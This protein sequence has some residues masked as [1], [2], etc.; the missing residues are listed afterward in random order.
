[1]SI[2]LLRQVSP[3]R[4]A[5]MARQ[6]HLDRALATQ[7]PTVFRQ[8]DHMM[9]PF[10]S[11]FNHSSTNMMTPFNTPFFQNSFA[12]PSFGSVDVAE[13]EVRGVE[14]RGECG[15]RDLLALRFTHKNR[16]PL[17]FSFSPRHQTSHV[18]TA[19]TPGLRSK[20]VR[21]CIRD[22]NILEMSGERKCES[23]DGVKGSNFYRMERSYGKFSRSFQLPESADTSKVSA[24][25][26]DGVLKIVIQKKEPSKIKN[27]VQEV[28][29]K[30][31]E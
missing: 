22:G 19:D 14:A 6:A 11:L 29:V 13:N 23:E 27:D 3:S 30:M 24:D 8:I 21:V 25:V 7:L 4:L 28:P 9:K 20:D 10:E 16:L 1:M 15:R 12:Q 18:I 26:K 31:A 5:H 17:T 2:T